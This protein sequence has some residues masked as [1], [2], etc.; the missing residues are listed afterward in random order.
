MQSSSEIVTTSK[1]TINFL[2]VGSPNQQCRST[3]GKMVSV[4]KCCILNVGKSRYAPRD[5]YLDGATLSRAPLYRDLGVIV[6]EDLKPTGH[7]PHQTDGR[8][9][10]S[11]LKRNIVQFC[12]A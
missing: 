5:F 7:S 11:T 12:V 4:N 6:S 1:L 8:Q 10:T 9:S 3:E 2:Q